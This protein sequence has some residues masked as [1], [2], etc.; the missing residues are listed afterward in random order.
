MRCWL[1]PGVTPFLPTI[2]YHALH[3]PSA[4]A[5][6]ALKARWHLPYG[7]VVHPMAQGGGEVPVANVMGGTIIRCK[8]CRTYI[9]PF[10]AWQDGGRC[11][12]WLG[13]AG[14]LAGRGCLAGWLRC[15]LWQLPAC[16]TTLWYPRQRQA[17]ALFV[18]AGCPLVPAATLPAI[19]SLP[20]S[21]FPHPAGATPAMSA[22]W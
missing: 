6:Q 2:H 13:V 12:G 1:A 8:R 9:N 10:M 7:A 15:A 16:A 17:I 21:L 18:Q 19:P 11:T 22:R 4:A 14:W 3:R 20:P 5:L